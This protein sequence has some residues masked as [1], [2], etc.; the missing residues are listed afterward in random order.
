MYSLLPYVSG[1]TLCQ[2]YGKVRAEKPQT[3][4]GTRA[5]S[6]KKFYNLDSLKFYSLSSLDRKQFTSKVWVDEKMER[7]WCTICKL[8]IDTYKL[9]HHLVSSTSAS[10]YVYSVILTLRMRLMSQTSTMLQLYACGQKFIEIFTLN[11]TENLKNA[12]PERVK[13]NQITSI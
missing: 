7:K 3:S 9:C 1:W 10:L 13:E 6:H 5:C 11:V 4:M 12:V 2:K 8:A